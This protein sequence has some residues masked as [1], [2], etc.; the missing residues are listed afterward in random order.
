G[1]V[2]GKPVDLGGSRGRRE[3]TRRG[4]VMVALEALR[5]DG[6]ENP[7]FAIEGFGNVGYEAAQWLCDK[8]YK[9]VAVSNST[10]ATHN[11]DGLDIPALRSHVAAT[12]SVPTFT[13]GEPIISAMMAPCEAFLPCALEGSITAENE[14]AIQARI[15]VEGANAPTTL[16]ADERLRKRGV[17][18]IPD[19]LANAGGV[20]VSYFE[21]VQN[22]E[23]FYWD[24]EAIHDQLQKKIVA[25]YRRVREY[26]EANDLSYREAAY[27]LALTRIAKGVEARGVQ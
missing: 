24:E 22:R 1:V 16:E 12:G 3:A 7:R 2:T 15:V 8:G 18:V 13:G 5:D 27:S 17:L 23:G 9:V 20:I 6:V 4:A 10:G 11:P 19:I 25:A 14:G 21:W 26:A